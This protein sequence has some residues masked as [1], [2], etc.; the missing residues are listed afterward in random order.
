[1]QSSLQSRIQEL[2]TV[3]SK[4]YSRHTREKSDGQLQILALENNM[5]VLKTTFEKLKA[6]VLGDSFV[7]N[8]VDNKV[9]L[10]NTK[11]RN[12]LKKL[13]P[14]SLEGT[15]NLS[16]KNISQRINFNKVFNTMERN[17]TRSKRLR[18]KITQGKHTISEIKD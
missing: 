7:C 15:S 12:N 4:V 10:Q 5:S 18:L 17:C 11:T 2:T 3:I 13:P 1:M 8:G 9:P 14:M 16:E 6:F